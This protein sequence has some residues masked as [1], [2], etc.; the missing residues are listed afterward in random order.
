MIVHELPPSLQ[1]RGLSWGMTLATSLLRLVVHTGPISLLARNLQ[2]P[3]LST[4]TDD[5]EC[6]NTAAWWLW[7]PI[8]GVES[9]PDRRKGL[10][11]ATLARL[12]FR[13]AL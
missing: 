9:L 6:S 12:D 11:D 4:Y 10:Q 5:L 8:A 3:P 1:L 7:S 2:Q 13:D